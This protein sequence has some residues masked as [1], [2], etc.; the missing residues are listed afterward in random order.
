MQLMK[1]QKRMSNFYFN[2]R[3]ILYGF[4]F[5]ALKFLYKINK[6]NGLFL[7][8]ITYLHLVQ[9]GVSQSYKVT[10]NNQTKGQV[11]NMR[12]EFKT[13]LQVKRIDICDLMLACLAAKELANDSGTKWDRLHDKLK[14]QLNELDTQ[15]DELQQNY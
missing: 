12:N 15:L 3:A 9:D 6:N 14:R 11:N 1:N 13:T 5:F 4:I 7:Y 8:K 2:Y 10:Q